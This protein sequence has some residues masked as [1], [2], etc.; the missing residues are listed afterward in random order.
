MQIADPTCVTLLCDYTFLTWPILPAARRGRS[1]G[2]RWADGR[3]VRSPLC[4]CRSSR[5]NWCSWHVCFLCM[6]GDGLQIRELRV[7]IYLTCFFG[8]WFLVSAGGCVI[9]AARKIFF[10]GTS[11]WLTALI[12]ASVTIWAAATTEAAEAACMASK[13][14]RA[15]MSSGLLCHA[16]ACCA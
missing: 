2:R 13:R 4:S 1:L 8:F 10:F 15:S 6:R 11:Y 14:M 7:L 9:A 5:R 12:V 3:G 16:A